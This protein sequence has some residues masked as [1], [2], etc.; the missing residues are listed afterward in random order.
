MVSVKDIPVLQWAFLP[1]GA[2]DEFNSPSSNSCKIPSVITRWPGKTGSAEDNFVTNQP[3]VGTGF[4]AEGEKNKDT[5]D[6]TPSVNTDDATWAGCLN[7]AYLNEKAVPNWTAVQYDSDPVH[8]D[9]NG[10]SVYGNC[11][12]FDQG[13]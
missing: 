13:Q 3:A 6:I 11:L 4:L 9:Q 8:P 2:S 12:Y 5:R 7:W 10:L 1:G